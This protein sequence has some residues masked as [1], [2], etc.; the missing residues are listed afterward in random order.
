MCIDNNFCRSGREKENQWWL[1]TEHFC[2]IFMEYLQTKTTKS[3]K[4]LWLFVYT[5]NLEPA[6]VQ[7]H[8]SNF[9]ILIF[10]LIMYWSQGASIVC[11][12]R[13]ISTVTILK[14]KYIIFFF[15]L[16]KSFNVICILNEDNQMLKI[17]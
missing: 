14:I 2:W 9:C 1:V 12:E 17:K 15:L 3:P 11:S 5:F 8:F 10:F 7:L 4:R 13:N 6:R 16:E